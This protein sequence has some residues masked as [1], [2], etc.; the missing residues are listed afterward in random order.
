M[1][2]LDVQP[3]KAVHAK[4]TATTPGNRMKT[5]TQNK[6][7]RRHGAAGIGIYEQEITNKV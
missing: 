2:E 4:R 7:D 5:C 6:T 1:L 3:A